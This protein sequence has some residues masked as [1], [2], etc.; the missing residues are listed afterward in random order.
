M[1]SSFEGDDDA[2]FASTLRTPAGRQDFIAPRL[3]FLQ[4]TLSV[5][6]ILMFSPN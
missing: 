6:Q 1:P 3:L 2:P 4:N 5:T